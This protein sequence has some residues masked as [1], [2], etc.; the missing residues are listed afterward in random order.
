[1]WKGEHCGRDV[2]VKVIRTYSNSDLQ[3][4]IGVSNWSCSLPACSRSTLRVEVLQ[5]GHDV[6][7]PPTSECPTADRSDDVRDSVRDDIGLDGERKYQ[8]LREGAPRCKPV[9]AGRL[10]A[11]NLMTFGSI[12]LIT[13]R[14]A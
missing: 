7:D 1:M 9:G 11:Q 3:K 4:I 8:R 10:F 14:F 5:G 12:S 2:A 6:E 13:G